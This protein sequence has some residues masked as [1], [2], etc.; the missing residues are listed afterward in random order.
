V[1][2]SSYDAAN[3][4]L[5]F[6][7]TTQTFDANGNLLTQTDVTGT[8][9]Y[10]WDARNRLIGMSGPSVSASFVYD[11][12]GRRIAKTIN[13][14]TTTFHYDGLDTV[15]ESG[16]AAEASYLRTL[17]IDEA[18][19]RSDPTGTVAYLTDTLGS[20]VALADRSGSPATEYTYEPFGATSVSG[21]P[22]PNPFQFTGRENDGTGLYYY[23]ARYYAPLYT[24][25]IAPDPIG[26]RAGPNLFSYARNSPLRFRDPLGLSPSESEACCRDRLAECTKHAIEG[27]LV[28]SSLVGVGAATC[29]A[30]AAAACLS[31]GPGFSAC[32]SIL[33]MKCIA[34]GEA[35]AAVCQYYYAYE[36]A[37]CVY[38]YNACKPH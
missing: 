3:Q 22:S 37:K 13:G 12:F 26:L 7:P 2:T 23:R 4:Q 17:N 38:D 18:L 6:G 32:F 11:A 8:T 35:G 9:T 36:I 21:L 30:A 25:F 5:A 34:A 29:T 31:T 19:T 15:R 20:T 27:D 28:C 33:S 1:P 10:T 14:Q 16:P 24:R